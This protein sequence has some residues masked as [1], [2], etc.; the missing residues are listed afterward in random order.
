MEAI[1]TWIDEAG[2]LDRCAQ[3]AA[4]ARRSMMPLV[5]ATTTVRHSSYETERPF[6]VAE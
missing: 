4:I 5:A 3:S 6:Y 1:T 2:A